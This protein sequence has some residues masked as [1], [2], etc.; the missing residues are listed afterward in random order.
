MTL[1]NDSE[2]PPMGEAL[3]API[4]PE[5]IY[6]HAGGDIDVM[7]V[8]PFEFIPVGGD[9]AAELPEPEPE[10]ASDIATRTHTVTFFQTEFAQKKI[11]M[12]LTLPTRGTS[13]RTRSR[14]G[15][16]R[17][18]RGTGPRRPADPARERSRRDRT[19]LCPLAGKPGRQGPPVGW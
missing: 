17:A 7:I 10:A 1:L 4:V 11:T 16:V 3:D 2:F 12:D 19:V 8:P 18:R 5:I 6:P 9:P 15:S 13:A 14:E